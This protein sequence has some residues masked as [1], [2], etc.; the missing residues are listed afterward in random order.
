MTAPL[1]E[2]VLAGFA[3]AIA[4]EASGFDAIPPTGLE[5]NGVQHTEQHRR[6]HVQM[7]PEK[8]K[9]KGQLFVEVARL[10]KEWWVS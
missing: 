1:A 4:F 9:E 6:F 5:T 7:P 3:G 10:N 2:T 8:F